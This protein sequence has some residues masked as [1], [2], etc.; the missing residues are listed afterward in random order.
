MLYRRGKAGIWWYSFEFGGKRIHE[1]TKSGSKTVA[2]DAE[3]A[4]RRQLEQ[5]WNQITKRMLPPAFERAADDWFEAAKPH[6]AERTKAID[7][8]RIASY[9]AKRKAEKASARTLNKELQVLRMI[10]KRHKLWANLQ[11]DVKFEREQDEVGKALS[12][13]DEARLLNLCAPNPL[14]D[15]V[16]TLDL[17]TALRTKELRLLCRDEVALIRDRSA[18]I[19]QLRQT[20]YDYYPAA[21]EAFDDWTMPAA[22]SFVVSFPTPEVLVKVG[23]RKREKFLHVHKLARPATYQRRLEI[24]ARA[25]QFAVAD[26]GR[27]IHV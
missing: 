27:P 20:L 15:T 23:K 6:L 2:R 17:N 5:S 9:Q 14:L 24:F 16:V 18:L 11:G 3:R 25:H 12:R 1:S 10:L 4:R 8:G 26:V 22:W 21:L 7:A 13:E 19:T